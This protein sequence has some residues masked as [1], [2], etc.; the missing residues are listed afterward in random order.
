V[1]DGE[2]SCS[3]AEFIESSAEAFE[4]GEE[5]GGFAPGAGAEMAWHFE[6]AEFQAGY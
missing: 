1:G 2:A 5:G 3:S 6:R 4:A